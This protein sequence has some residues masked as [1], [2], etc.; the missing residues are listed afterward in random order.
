MYGSA[1]LM[2][3]TREEDDMIRLLD[4]EVAEMLLTAVEEKR[5]SS[6]SRSHDVSEGG[7]I[8]NADT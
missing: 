5:V 2:S 4:A 8:G 3:R 7:D 6:F 1:N